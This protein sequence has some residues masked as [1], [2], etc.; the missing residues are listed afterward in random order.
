LLTAAWKKSRS[1]LISEDSIGTDSSNTHTCSHP[2]TLPPTS[3]EPHEPESDWW[4][5][6]TDSAF[7]PAVL[8]SRED[9][10]A[11]SLCLH[12]CDASVQL[13]QSEEGGKAKQ[14]VTSESQTVKA[15]LLLASIELSSRFD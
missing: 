8:S 6:S 11:A 3:A 7:F 13:H 5:V 2:G 15:F 1:S 14:I 4:A 10:A 12:K 9:A